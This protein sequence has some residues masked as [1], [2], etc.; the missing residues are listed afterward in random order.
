M[1]L[2][3]S[4]K[5]FLIYI[6]LFFGG[7][8]IDG[9]RG[10]DL[11]NTGSPTGV[12]FWMILIIFLFYVS[13]KKKKIEQFNH[14]EKLVRGRH[15]SQITKLKKKIDFIGKNILDSRKEAFNQVSL[16]LKSLFDDKVLSNFN[17]LETD[18]S[19]IT[20]D[21]A[22]F[23]KK[24]YQNEREFFKSYSVVDLLLITGK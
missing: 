5:R 9:F 19:V 16:T 13:R 15:N 1:R 17:C 22:N 3:S 6:F 4:N 2:P 7:P 12:I 14:S 21:I 8:I 23:V 10:V 20:T 24:E 11:E 18:N